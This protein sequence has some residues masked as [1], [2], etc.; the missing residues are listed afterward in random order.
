MSIFYYIVSLYK[1]TKAHR[2]SENNSQK[3][4][5]FNLENKSFTLLMR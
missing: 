3:Q 5:V 2:N 4:T 1:G